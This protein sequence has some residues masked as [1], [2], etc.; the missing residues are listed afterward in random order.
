[1]YY[2][3]E[4]IGE[5]LKNM[6]KKIISILVCM[7]LITISMAMIGTT[8]ADW[9]PGDGHKMHFPQLPDPYG[10]DVYATAGLDQYPQV[11]VADD[12]KCSETGYIRDIHFWGS[13]R[14]GI[15]GEILYFVITLSEDIPA[16]PPQIPYSRPGETLKEWTIYEWEESPPIDPP[17]M[18]GWYEPHNNYWKENDHHDYYQYNVDLDENEWYMQ[19]KDKIYWLGISAVVVDIENPVSQPFWGWKTSD[20][21]QY[22]EPYAGMHYIDDAV[23][24]YWYQLD[25]Q[26]ILEPPVLEPKTNLFWAAFDFNGIFEYGGGTDY[27]DDGTSEYGW[28][29]YENTNWWNIWFYDHPFDPDRYKEIMIYIPW[30]PYNP[31][32]PTTF[33][34]VAVNWATNAWNDPE[35]PPIPPLT[36]Q[37]EDLYIGREIL[38]ATEVPNGEQYLFYTIPDYNPEWV[39]VDIRGN[40]F[41]IPQGMG[42]IEHECLRSLDMAFVITDEEQ[43]PPC[44]DI[45]KKVSI[46]GGVT[47]TDEVDAKINDVVKFQLD[48]HNCNTPDLTN[49]I[50][51]DTLPECLEYVANSATP[52]EPTITGSTLKW[53]FPGPLSYCN[54]K[55]ITF[56]A[57]VVSTGENINT[58]IVTAQGAG[59]SV[60]DSDSATVNGISLVPDLTCVGSLSWT[61]VK[62]DSVQN[63]EFEVKNEGDPG[64]LLHWSITSYPDWAS[65]T[66]S[67]TSGPNLK[68]EDGPVTISVTIYVPD[69]TEA[70]YSGKIKVVNIYDPTDSC[71]VDV[72]LETGKGTPKSLTI[73][74]PF[75]RIL[76]NYPLLKFVLMQLFNVY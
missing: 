3:F 33:L 45:E 24:G 48:I 12:F 44:I 64:S 20:T 49:I 31:Q 62:P 1:L 37:R 26:E 42:Y 50:V 76:Q 5:V 72:D 39:S 52:F 18:Q 41:V 67:P 73:G 60:V 51:V 34:E 36:P 63:G 15:V 14:M 23:W 71:E 19:Q 58:A 4:L 10:W 8:V 69:E 56:D 46:D 61:K 30:H 13:W 57:K 40:N 32:Y 11:S 17:G 6:N 55:I 27:F 53:T 74:L 75:I 16:N 28:Y 70:T 54:H 22:P 9:E 35:K 25:W 59:A 47:W 66:I 38:L 68:P 7:L 21:S 65:F 2:N 43:E 29:Y